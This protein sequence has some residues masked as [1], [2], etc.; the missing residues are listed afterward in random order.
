MASGPNTA[1]LHLGAAYYPEHWPPERWPED[2]RLM[3][4]AG[5]SVVRMAE[6]AWSTMEPEED[7]FDFAW[8]DSAIELL[9]D[10]GIVT[11]LGTPTAAPP[12]W[13]VQSHP[14]L[15]AVEAGGQRVQFGNRCH[16]CVT[17][18]D[19][20]VAARRIA[21]MMGERFG[22]HP[23][24]IGWQLDN[25][26]NRVCYCD[27]CRGQ[28][29]EYLRERFGSLDALNTAWS[30]RYWSQTYSAWEQMP[31]PIGPHNPGLMLEF[32]RFVTECYRRFQRLVIDELRPHLRPEVWITHNFM[33]WFDA[34]D[35]YALT[36]DLD[37]ASWDWYIGTGHH[38]HLVSGAAHD[39][40]RGFKR[41]NY[42]V[43]ETQVGHTNHL[44]VN[45]DLN[46]GEARAMAWHAVA[47]GAD[48]LLYWQW[49]M[50]PGGQEQY[51]GTIVDQAG[52]ARPYL[53][54]VSEIG[55]DFAAVGELLTDT[56]P[57]ADIAILNSYDDRWA[58]NIH[59]H[60]E[61]FDYVAHLLHYYR[62][63][64]ERNIAAEI[65]STD[66]P[67][68]GY[69]VVIAPAHHLLTE[70]RVARLLAFVEQGGHLVLTL[71]SGVKDDAN[72]LLPSR[73]PGPLADAAG[74]EVEDY[75]A[76]AEPVPVLGDRFTGTS[77]IWAERLNVRDVPGTEIIARFGP[78]NGWLD[79]HPAITAHPWGNGKVYFIG[80]WLDENSQR[81]LL[82][83]IAYD[84][85]IEPIMQ[86]PGG[87]EA[88]QRVNGQGQEVLIVVN[89]ERAPR[90]VT[91]PWLADDHLTDARGVEEV[92]LAPYGVG[93][94][95]RS[96]EQPR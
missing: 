21:R 22:N 94:F 28:F 83:R 30:T 57:V 80:A 81:A 1:R 37:M 73:P 43:M 39:L 8:L 69:K 41:R 44:P 25:E 50:A 45:N 52:R 17:S 34:F 9:A 36:A 58:I 18:P 64:A 70:E 89:H 96:Q 6:F 63:L 85:G 93:V 74:V 65:I 62:P 59:R 66:A 53:E 13:L 60:H 32:R 87:V 14:D 54:E 46:R 67:L 12:A 72:A 86:T 4:E 10:A 27:R 49:R 26:Y 68:D 91:L 55:R 29:Q 79:G 51:W 82:D 92:H 16:Y 75:Y 23:S 35:H 90:V 5:F 88:R 24:V 71:R 56:E 77:S 95:T 61:D 3:R 11:V 7:S 42:W 48:A 33:G 20:H 40:T 2:I 84:A 76:L 31:I 78:S 38:D 15:L 19:L 47:H